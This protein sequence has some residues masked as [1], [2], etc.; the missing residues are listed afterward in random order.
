MDTLW[1][2]P[3]IANLLLRLAERNN[4]TDNKSNGA[5]IK[6][7]FIGTAPVGLDLKK[8]LVEKFGIRAYENFGLSETTFLSAELPGS[9]ISDSSGKIL[10]CIDYKLEPVS[11]E[12]DTAPSE[13]YV[14][15][16]SCLKAT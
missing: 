8:S 14:K 3:S 9:Q 16:P 6:T 2:V 7:A 4:E 5:L 12:Y 10:D 1:F 11:Y 13:L 15:T